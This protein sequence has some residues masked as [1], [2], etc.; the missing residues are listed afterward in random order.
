MKIKDTARGTIEA[1]LRAWGA[2]LDKLRAKVD[3]T[4]GGARGK[5]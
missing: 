3:G 5:T 4:P 2:E 1:Q